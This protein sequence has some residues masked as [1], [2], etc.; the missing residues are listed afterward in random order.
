MVFRLERVKKFYH[1]WIIKQELHHFQFSKHLFVAAHLI[2]YELFT[3]GF[4]NHDF[5][6]FFFPRKINFL[7]EST[8]TNYFKFLKIV[9]T[10]IRSLLLRTL[11]KNGV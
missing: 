6:T 2:E 8:L 10:C 5:S 1:E 4:N 3:H 7:S 9:Q 11:T